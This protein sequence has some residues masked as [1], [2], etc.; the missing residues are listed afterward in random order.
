MVL[1]VLGLATISQLTRSDKPEDFAFLAS[2]LFVDLP[3]DGTARLKPTRAEEV[4][5]LRKQIAKL[6]HIS[7]RSRTLSPIGAKLLHTMK[8]AES[9]Q[10]KSPDVSNFILGL[11]E[12]GLGL[13]TGQRDTVGTG[14]QKVL[15]EAKSGVDYLKEQ[16]AVIEEKSILAVEMLDLV[17]KFSGNVTTT[18]G[19]SCNFE[20]LQTSIFDNR[21]ALRVVNNSGRDL[22]N[23][24][25]TVRLSNARGDSS[26]SLFFTDI[27]RNAEM[28][29]AA[30]ARFDPSKNQITVTEVDRVVVQIWATELSVDPIVLTEQGQGGPGKQKQR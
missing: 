11:A 6:D 28:R 30:Y 9:L 16:A 2:A 12:A 21:S 13:Y 4:V 3:V 18:P 29:T 14:G 20:G 27:W 22:H 15:V 5:N 10:H 17:P 26:L 24:V 1:G 19:F 23:C 7:R 8:R 25:A